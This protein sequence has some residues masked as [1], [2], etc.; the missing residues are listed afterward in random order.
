MLGEFWDRK[1]ARALFTALVFA[2]ALA[3]LYA[4]QQTLTL[5]LFAILFAYFA[6][7]LVSK[8]EKPLR[9]RIRAITA[10][11][12]ILL[13]LLVGLGML[14]GP[15][16]ADSAKSLAQSLPTLATK[17]SS[18]QMVTEVG[19]THG[20]TQHRQAQIR[21]FFVEHR[22]QL[23]G[24]IK[25]VGAKLAEPA[26]HI[27]WLI[28]I[29]ILSLFFLKDGEEIARGLVGLGRDPSERATLEGVVSDVNIMLGSY[30]R[31]QII[32]ASLTMVAYTVVLSLMRVPYSFIL[33]P[34]AGVFEFIPVVGP[35]VA[36]VTVFFIA[37]LSGYSHLVWL[38]IFLGAWRL[39][40]DYVNAP[41][42]MGESLEI[43]PLAQ[44]FAVLAG[45]EIGGVV[46]ALISVPV[47]ATLRI[48]WRRLRSPQGPDAPAVKQVPIDSD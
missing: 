38:F 12:S 31:S 34:L 19:T 26:S 36:A 21:A 28:L 37:V 42:I 4:A 7:P 32:L 16:V 46:G 20:W 9:G 29:P 30:I 17:V 43:S 1:T 22:E 5:F 13:I 10:V 33:G 39:M 27:W 3:F 24:Y 25:V 18:G 8:L 2:A 14:L 45:G 47:L 44:I 41:R 35:A 11:Y 6:A 15:K 40:Q 23:L 48:V